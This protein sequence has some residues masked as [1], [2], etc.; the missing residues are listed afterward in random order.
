MSEQD[1]KAVEGDLVCKASDG[2][3]GWYT[4]ERAEHDGR[5][6]MEQRDFGGGIMGGAFMMSCRITDACVEGDGE[7]MLA[8]A[9]AIGAG[10]AASFKRCEAYPHQGGY[11]L[12]SPRNS[13]YAALVPMDVA[14]RLAASIR[15]TVKGA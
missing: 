7:E 3:E 8:L 9:K 15:A 1:Y 12:S 2:M 6:W 4:I 13:T 10:K 14:E 11:A 5:T